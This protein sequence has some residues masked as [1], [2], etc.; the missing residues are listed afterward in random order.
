MEHFVT[1]FDSLFLPQGLA[2]H[3][4]L[5]THAGA[6]T[7]WVLCMDEEAKQIL[8]QL[9][10]PNLKTIALAD[11]ETPELL[12]VKSERTRG[13]Y[14]WTITPFTPRIVFTRDASVQRVTY[15]D[16]D[17]YFLKE[18]QPI[19]S[20]FVA[21]GKAVLITEHAYAPNHDKSATLGVYCVQFV[22]FVRDASEPVRQ[23][24]QERCLEW[25]YARAENGKFGDQKYLDHWPE[26]FPEL[27][28]VLQHPEWMLA[29]WNATRF[30]YSLGKIYHFHGLRILDAASVTLRPV[31]YS[32]PKPLVEQVYHPYLQSLKRAIQ[33]LAEIGFTV[34]SQSARVKLTPKD[35]IKLFLYELSKRLHKFL[36]YEALQINRF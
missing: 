13:E 28:H 30:P 27:V 4:S 6:Y 25:C 10:L 12:A 32:L 22:T 2:L 19:F 14:C 8:D 7:L 36:E 9:N 34:K 5:E 20:E 26:T 23:W 17:L 24:W 31:G 29:P 3:H 16:A 21:S 18:V 35:Q 1:L 33:A 15:L 11:V